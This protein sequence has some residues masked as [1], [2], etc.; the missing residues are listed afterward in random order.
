MLPYCHFDIEESDYLTSARRDDNFLNALQ[1]GGGDSNELSE[2]YQNPRVVEFRVV[3]KGESHVKEF[4]LINPTTENYRFYWKDLTLRESDQL[5]FFHCA[6][7][8]DV[9]ESGKRTKITFSFF[10]QEI[11]TFQAFWRFSIDRY[12]LQTLFLLVTTITEPS[13]HFSETRLKMKPTIVGVKVTDHLTIVNDENS[14]FSWKILAS[15]LHSEEGA[16]QK[17]VGAPMS[18]ILDGGSKQLVQ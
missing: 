13:I 15:S 18:G 14:S 16:F 11:G 6:R 17:L 8:Q 4:F 9:A 1:A 2:E 5:P 7:E 10:A 3:G 12:D